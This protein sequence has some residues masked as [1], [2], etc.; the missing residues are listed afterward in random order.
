MKERGQPKLYGT[1]RAKSEVNVQIKENLLIDINRVWAYLYFMKQIILIAGPNGA[2]KTTFAREFLPKEATTI[3]FINAD[4]IALGLSP[5]AP[6]SVAIEASKLLLSRINE[7]C[8]RADSFGL[9]STLSG[10]SYLR[11]IS[12]W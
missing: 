11:M 1:C 6:E 5:F 2:G 9:E 4:L 8:K 10:K 12:D 7:C 3:I